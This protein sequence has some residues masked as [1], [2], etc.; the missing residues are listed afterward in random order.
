MS[1]GW[2]K[3]ASYWQKQMGGRKSR[4]VVGKESEY[5]TFVDKC[6]EET[7][8]YA[9]AKIGYPNASLVCQRAALTWWW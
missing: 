3:K 9:I 6:Y 7:L 1:A 4:R 2:T 8:L 5:N